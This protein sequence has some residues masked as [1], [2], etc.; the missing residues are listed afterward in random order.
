M[1]RLLPCLICIPLLLAAC[2]P[3]RDPAEK[4]IRNERT[5]DPVMERFID[6]LVREMT[7]EEKAGQMI[8]VPCEQPDGIIQQVNPGN[9]NLI[10]YSSK[11]AIDTT[12]LAR[13]IQTYHIGSWLQGK[14]VTAE[15]WCRFN[16]LMQEMNLKHSRLKIPMIFGIDFAHGA[17]SMRDGTIFPHNI[18]MGATFSKE[19]NYKAAWVTSVESAPFGFHWVFNPELDLGHNIEWCRFFETYGEDPYLCSVLGGIYTKALQENEFHLPYRQAACARHY[20]GYSD[21]CSGKDRGPAEIS[22]QK[23]HEFFKPSFQVAIDS[24]LMSL[25]VCSGEINGIPVHMSKY[26]LT[27]IL[28]DEL[29][30]TGVALSDWEDVEKLVTMHGT[31]PDLKE[32]AF[33]CIMAGLDMSMAQNDGL[34]F[35]TNIV[36]LVKEGRI[37]EKRIDLSVRRILRM[38]YILGLF[39]HPFPDCSDFGYVGKKEHREIAARTAG[40][41]IV[42]LKNKDGFLPISQPAKILLA[43]PVISR[44]TPLCGSWTYTQ[45]GNSENLYPP[46]MKTIWQAVVD[47]F[48]CNNVDSA[49]LSDLTVKAAHAD[50]LILVIGSHTYTEQF[51]NRGDLLPPHAQITLMQDAVKTGKPVILLLIGG[52]PLVIDEK[53]I[54][55]AEAVIWAGLPGVFGAPAI[56]EILS[57]KVNPSG[58]LPFSYPAHLNL[59]VPYNH[60]LSE[61]W[62]M[63]RSLKLCLYPFGHGLSYTRFEYSDLKLSDT[64]V[65]PGKPLTAE[66]VVTNMGDIAGKESV[67]WYV[68]DE[69]GLISRPVREL[70]Y[71][72]KEHFMPGESRVFQF[73]LSPETDLTY[74]GPDGEPILEPGSF[75]ISVGDFKARIWLPEQISY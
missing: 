30:F 72:E 41:S 21:P 15:E 12:E 3:E 14:A 56:A 34:V 64:I 51:G 39:D 33:L 18:N 48:G 50:V 40:E 54:E 7:L 13:L 22:R 43:G 25:M 37:S 74:P 63:L 4:Y 45:G 20:M 68:S 47:E 19:L 67:L 46:G 10:T 6:S 29:G 57:G 73:I 75:M 52:R 28:R 32:A 58:K 66:V 70:R 55:A 53:V 36:E 26:I 49:N 61:E 2:S 9:P 16:T 38:K 27:E 69:F 59:H 1:K 60:K 44:K 17:S 71:F 8:Q 35:C 42:L 31:V 23:L 11:W 24:G 65:V 5:D 62:K